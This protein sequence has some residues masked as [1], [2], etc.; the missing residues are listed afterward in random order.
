MREV[1][2]RRSLQLRLLGAFVGVAAV[3]VAA[4]AALTL[5]VGRG[6][7]QQLVD[8]QHQTA[9]VSTSQ[10]LSDAYRAAGGWGAA[11][12]RPAR[13]VALSSGAVLQVQDTSGATVAAPGRGM[14][15]G[16]GGG[17][18]MTTATGPLRTMRVVVDGRTVGTASLHFM[19]SSLPPAEQQ[20]RD[21]L[22]RTVIWGSAIALAV[23]LAVAYFVAIGITRP[24]QRLTR[25]VQRLGS[26]DRAA[27]ANLSAPGE[28]GVLAEEVDAMA[29]KLEREEELRRALTADVA[30]ELRTPVSIL[31][32]HCEAIVDG[33][34]E[35]S[36]ELMSS[37]YDEVVR[38]GNL[39]ED[40]ET[41]SA[42]EAAGLRLQRRPVDLN[43]IVQSS[44][45]LL[46]PHAEAAEVTVTTSLASFDAVV[47]GDAARLTQI[48]RNLL[49]NAL[50][51]TPAGGSVDVSVTRERTQIKL[52]VGDTGRG[53]PAD[54]LPHVFDRFWRGGEAA[55]TSGS[56]IGLAVV[57]E[58][59]GVHGGTVSVSSEPGSGSRFTVTLPAAVGTAVAVS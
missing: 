47:A 15:A 46:A 38:L 7:V 17:M 54:E 56:G 18:A 50:K 24:L 22:S 44:V 42:A 49:I 19:T 52:E 39:I 23:A 11:D 55:M 10:A 41:L 43:E 34:E 45:A 6:N 27:R 32:A 26:G 21:A 40:V 16:M 33:V 28:L 30:H 12:I 13:A 53:I 1:A 51:F 5:W 57:R 4:F 14:G 2:R 59:A 9:L 25:A 35:P 48:V 8:R 58:L 37:L 3:A 31:R 36:P 29:A 20:L